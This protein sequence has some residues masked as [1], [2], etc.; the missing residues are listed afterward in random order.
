MA[1]Y[2]VGTFIFWREGRRQ[3]YQSEKL[4]D[5]SLLS[6]IAA[7]VGGRLYG[8]LFDLGSAFDDPLS[9][10]AFWR[11]D[12]HFFGA[13]F[14]V[15]SVGLVFTRRWKWTT[16]Q[17]ADFSFLAALVALIF[18]KTGA[19]LAGVEYGTASSLPWA[20]QASSLLGESHPVQLYEAGYAVLLF[21]IFKKVY[22]D[23]L[24]EREI[25]SGKVF[26]QGLFFLS[27]GR[28]V[29][30]LF[31]ADSIY[32]FGM[33]SAQIVSLLVALVSLFTLYYLNLRNLKEDLRGFLKFIL[34]VNGRVLRRLR[35]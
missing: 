6:L 27:S 35:I 16:L 5:L 28:F 25:K 7:L 17:V 30:E 31:R 18:A 1:A 3:G 15:I 11:G 24:K 9:L 26:L 33:K 20:T 14:G 10:L 23:N 34:S 2:I 29:F 8:F 13:L 19:F 12:L 4:L 22:E 21:V 32:I